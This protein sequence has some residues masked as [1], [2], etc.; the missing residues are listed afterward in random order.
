MRTKKHIYG[1]DVLRAVAIL[2]VVLHHFLLMFRSKL[3]V[4]ES[5]VRLFKL[6][7]VTIFFVLSGYLIGSILLRQLDKGFGLPD[8]RQFWIR[9]WLRTLPAYFVVLLAIF[10]QLFWYRG[11][12][13]QYPR[14]FL[15]LQCIH[16]GKAVLYPESWSLCVEEWFYLLIPIAVLLLP[17]ARRKNGILAGLLVVII[18]SAALR[19][20]DLMPGKYE[21]YKSSG[22]HRRT[23]A[24]MDG[25][26]FG[27]LAA[28]MHYYR[29]VQR[30]KMLFWS[31][32][33]LCLLM[34]AQFYLFGE[35]LIAHY[36][37][38]TLVPLSIMMMI[39]YVATITEGRGPF[40]RF[41][42]FTALIS[43]PLY[44]IHWTPFFQL[45]LVRLHFLPVPAQVLL[46][47]TWAYGGA[48]VLHRLVERP[49]MALRERWS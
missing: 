46:F 20:W 36:C 44:L 48:Y 40:A 6:D 32:I 43:Y 15:F 17:A 27:V 45:A 14:Y 19:V 11:W 1:L 5:T 47:V 23:F 13:D 7:G 30:K 37:W 29:P 24:R 3:G 4:E 49:F 12:S 26:A 10:G 22:L 21:V 25:I 38:Y 31:G 42:S 35:N 2:S 8:L 41:L 33:A 16:D 9:R 34:Q 18:L 39:P 28:W